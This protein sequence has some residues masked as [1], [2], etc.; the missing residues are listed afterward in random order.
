MIAYEIQ[1]RHVIRDKIQS[2]TKF[3][4]RQNPVQDK[5]QSEKKSKKNFF[6]KK[7]FVRK[8]ILSE[9]NL[10]QT[11]SQISSAQSELSQTNQCLSSLSSMYV[12]HS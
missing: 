5:F 4:Q 9:T 10:S 7:I 1:L 11:L 6:T 2:E 12:G 3:S 8:K